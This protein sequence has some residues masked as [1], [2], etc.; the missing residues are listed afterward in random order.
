MISPRPLLPCP[1]ARQRRWARVGAGTVAGTALTNRGRVTKEPKEGAY[2][3]E[4]PA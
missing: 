1:G 3:H 2:G 4:A